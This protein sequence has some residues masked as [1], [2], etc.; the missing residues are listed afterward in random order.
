MPPP[1]PYMDYYQPINFIIDDT[2]GVYYFRQAEHGWDCGPSKAWDAPPDFIDLK[3]NDIVKLP[4]ENIDT[5][6]TKNLLPLTEGRRWVSIG[7]LKDTIQS[8]G[9]SKIM[10]ACKSP[11]NGIVWDFRSA[12][13]E[14]RQ[15]LLRKLK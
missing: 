2:G 10:A 4:T 12:T 9:L 3:S 1:P 13:E 15:A 11:S 6:I 7:S 5:F 14:E 8:V